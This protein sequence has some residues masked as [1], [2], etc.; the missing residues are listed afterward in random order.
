MPPLPDRGP[1]STG[2]L[3][4]SGSAFHHIFKPKGFSK[5]HLQ[6][7]L[8]NLPPARQGRLRH[9]FGNVS[10]VIQNAFSWGGEN[11]WGGGHFGGGGE[12]VWLKTAFPGTAGTIGRGGV[13]V[14]SK[15]GGGEN[16]P[17]FWSPEIKRRSH[18]EPQNNLQ[19]LLAQT[20]VLPPGGNGEELAL[21]LHLAFVTGLLS[22]SNVRGLG[23]RGSLIGAAQPKKRGK[24]L[25]PRTSERIPARNR[26]ISA[27]LPLPRFPPPFGS[28]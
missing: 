10:A 26:K 15:E 24:P 11:V 14:W 18:P 23:M 28:V 13:N 25:H 8:S 16:V 20:S 22:D 27:R 9:C 21:R 5:G 3:E 6:R 17:N 4:H 1:Y 7:N 12:N 19:P 2:I